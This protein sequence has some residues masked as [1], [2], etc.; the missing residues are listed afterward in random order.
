M[1]VSN[2]V[3]KRF[4]RNPE[5]YDSRA[6]VQKTVSA[7]LADMISASVDKSGVGSIMEIGCGTG[8]LTR[9]LFR[10][11][12]DAEIAVTDL[13][14]A[15]LAYCERS[16]AAIADELG[17]SVEFAVFDASL[18]SPK[19]SL[20]LIASSLAFQWIEDF[21]GLFERL[22]SALSDGGDLAFATLAEG[23]FAS[24]SDSF[25]SHGLDLPL[26]VLP[27]LA[28]LKV[29]L[30]NFAEVELRHET[31]YEEFDSIGAF[32]RHLRDVGAGNATGNPLPTGKLA[33]FIREN[34]DERVVAEYKVVYVLCRR[35]PLRS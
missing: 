27:T 7:N 30:A 19:C 22:R 8:F 28:E 4:S 16:T 32:L 6:D 35:G 2:L 13:S 18:D 34:R 12:P 25:A 11:F 24:V 20:D 9:R 29:A 26:P 1:I 31:L 21:S 14:S 33:K 5:Y 17:V 3:E 10:L 15:M 23:T